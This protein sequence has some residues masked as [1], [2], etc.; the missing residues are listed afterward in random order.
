M[1]FT[2]ISV[3]ENS[4]SRSLLP[5]PQS[6]RDFR[7]QAMAQLSGQHA[8]LST[9]MCL[10]SDEVVEEMYEVSREVLPGR[11]RDRAATCRA[12]PDHVNDAFAAAFKSTRQV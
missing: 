1:P 5:L 2:V 9:V 8:E 11:R 3:I 7:R 6:C 10:V 12:E 4:L